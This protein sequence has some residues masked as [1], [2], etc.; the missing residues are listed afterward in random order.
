M[1]R[2]YGHQGSLSLCITAVND[3][4][5]CKSYVISDDVKN[6]IH[7][8]QL[9]DAIY[10]TSVGFRGDALIELET[11][12]KSRKQTPEDKVEFK[13]AKFENRIYSVTKC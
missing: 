2:F 1:G 10:G 13:L 7:G 11:L 4:H 9:T 6:G 3:P 12:S 8:T 5:R